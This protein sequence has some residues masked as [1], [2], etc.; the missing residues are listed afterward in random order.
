M[1]NSPL[2][3]CALSARVWPGRIRPN[4]IIACYSFKS[5]NNLSHLWYIIKHLCG[6]MI[7]LQQKQNTEQCNNDAESNLNFLIQALRHA[8]F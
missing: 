6:Q 2:Y 8:T 7:P 4:V 3:P 5:E 1:R